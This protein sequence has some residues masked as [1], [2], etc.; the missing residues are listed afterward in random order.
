MKPRALRLLPGLLI[1]AG[2]R[3]QAPLREARPRGVFPLTE[4]AFDAFVARGAAALLE[5]A[6]RDGYGL[7]LRLSTPVLARS[8]DADFT[9]L[10]A[11]QAFVHT[12][13]GGLADRA[14]GAVQFVPEG[15]TARFRAMVRFARFG[16][17]PGAASVTLSVSDSVTQSELL[18]CSA[19]FEPRGEP[20]RAPPAPPPASPHPA[21][22]ARPDR[23]AL[24][25][26][27]TPA[28]AILDGEESQLLERVR[29][30]AAWHSRA[31]DSLNGQVVVLSDDL[32]RR[33]DIRRRSAGKDS[34]GRLRPEL[35]IVSRRDSPLARVRVL[36]LDA[37]GRQIEAT[38]VLRY[39]LV[40]G[41]PVLISVVAR[42]AQ[43]ET[44]VAL[45][46]ADAP[47]EKPPRAP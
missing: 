30:S 41:Y 32:W 2:C 8:Q 9:D 31:L 26:P 38:P 16:T 29:G 27:D 28:A 37:A 10:D 45:V 19:A 42:S 22:A 5:A 18:R 15:E 34:D 46:D 39:G 6:R 13:A 14:A 1:L 43:A 36:F 23:P 24:A 12:L 40:E 47:S 4:P 20:P 33:L 7:P 11:A 25:A 44:F 17:Q 3:S 35:E 21:R